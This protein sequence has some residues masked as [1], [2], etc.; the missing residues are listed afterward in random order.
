[1]QSDG[2]Q[3]PADTVQKPLEPFALCA[4]EHLA[5]VM[6]ATSKS[7]FCSAERIGVEISRERERHRTKQSCEGLAL[8]RDQQP[9]VRASLRWLTCNIRH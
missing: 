2:G 8:A 3:G 9:I 4:D 5:G 7:I 6:R 1:M